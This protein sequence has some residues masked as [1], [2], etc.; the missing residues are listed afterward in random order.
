MNIPRFSRAACKWM[1]IIRF[2]FCQEPMQD[3]NH[4]QSRAYS[5]NLE[6]NSRKLFVIPGRPGLCDIEAGGVAA[7]HDKQF[8][9]VPDRGCPADRSSSPHRVPGLLEGSVTESRTRGRDKSLRAR[10]RWNPSRTTML[11]S[12]TALQPRLKDDQRTRP[13]PLDTVFPEGI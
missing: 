4:Q 3:R 7:Q 11:V 9:H 10:A 13:I 12:L 2:R 5:S 6:P 8:T 1:R